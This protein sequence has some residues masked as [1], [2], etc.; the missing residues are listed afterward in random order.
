MNDHIKT[1]TMEQADILDDFSY[2]TMSHQ[3]RVEMIMESNR[4]LHCGFV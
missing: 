3:D 4:K 1:I 2:G